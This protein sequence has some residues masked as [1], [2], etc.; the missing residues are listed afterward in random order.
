MVGRHDEAIR[1]LQSA[2]ELNPNLFFTRQWLGREYLVKGMLAQAI[3]EFQA[4]PDLPSLG[5]PYAVNGQ[6]QEAQRILARMRANPLTNSFD[7]AIV[8][9]GLGRTSEALD[10]LGQAYQEHILW[11]MFM[12]IDER[13][14]SL[15]GTQ[16]FEAIA[17]AMKLP[18]TR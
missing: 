9:A 10:L 5:Y 17:A 15:R 2:V 1:Q 4:A 13:L 7:F 11:L 16:Q 14:A 3:Q 8:N 6:T 18:P 12:R